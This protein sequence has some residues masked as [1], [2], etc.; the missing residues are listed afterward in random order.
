MNFTTTIK[1]E[2]IEKGVSSKCCKKAFLSG[3][4]RSTGSICF[5]DGEYGFMCETDILSA[6]NY[7]KSLIKE[8]YGEV[9]LETSSYSDKLNKKERFIIE[10]FGEKAVSILFDL[11]ILG[12]G[13]AGD[14]LSLRLKSNKALL[15]KDCCIKSFIKGVFIGGGQATLPSANSTTGYHLEVAFNHAVPAGEYAEWLAKFGIFAKTIARRHKTVVYFKSAEEIADF[16]ALINAPKSVIKITDT[17]ISNQFSNNVNRQKNCDI[18]NVNKQIVANEKYLNAIEIISS[19][20]GLNSL[21]SE[22]EKTAKLKQQY[23]EDTL[24]ELAER[25]GVTKSCLNHRL[26]KLVQIAEELK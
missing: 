24:S 18:A 11:G 1:K 15:Q 14:E 16:L 26:R 23:F 25:L 7:A 3:F 12:E 19:T 10:T 9:V 20:I 22:L 8:I 13:E 2:I 17:V 5:N 6:V 4:I 21:D